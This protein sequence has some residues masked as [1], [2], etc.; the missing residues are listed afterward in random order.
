MKQSNDNRD[1]LALI[2][3]YGMNTEIEIWACDVSLHNILVQ[4]QHSPLHSRPKQKCALQQ[5]H[6]ITLQILQ[7]LHLLNVI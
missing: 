5:L 6:L 2:V 7:L 3:A 1:I 4:L